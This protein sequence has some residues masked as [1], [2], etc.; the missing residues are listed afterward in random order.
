MTDVTI[1]TT[2]YNHEKYLP[3]LVDGVVS[4]SHK[5]NIQ[6]NFINDGSTDGSLDE[7]L[8]LTRYLPSNIDFTLI[9]NGV[10]QGA[11]ESLIRV[12]SIEPRGKY[13]TI[14]EADDYWKPNFLEKTLSFLE[15][16]PT[17]SAVH[18]DTDYMYPDRLE[19]SHWKNSG[20]F[21]D[22]GHNL[23]PIPEGKIF[24]ELIKNNFIMTCSFIGKTECF[25]KYNKVSL[26]QKPPFEYSFTDYPFYLGLSRFN[27]IGYID[28]S[29]AVYR[30]NPSG[31]SN[32]PETRSK[33]IQDTQKIKNDALIGR[34]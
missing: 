33:I 7:I 18:T 8:R 16:N 20:R 32:N 19:L 11:F 21:D 22:S 15:A 2:C 12:G 1:L 14:L 25:L 4:Q 27:N 26:F 6:W 13:C 28:K 9:S 34:I 31:A 10:N 30:I 24:N 29:L 17:Y 5:A 3:S 23:G